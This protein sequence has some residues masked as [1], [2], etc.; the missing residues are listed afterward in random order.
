[1]NQDNTYSTFKVCQLEDIDTL[2]S[3]IKMK[4]NFRLKDYIRIIRKVEKT[5]MPSRLKKKMRQHVLPLVIENN[6]KE[7]AEQQTKTISERLDDLKSTIKEFES[8]QNIN[9][10]KNNNENFWNKEYK[11]SDFTIIKGDISILNYHLKSK[12]ITTIKP[13]WLVGIEHVFRIAPE[14]RKKAKAHTNQFHF[15]PYTDLSYLL[16]EVKRKVDEKSREANEQYENNI[17]TRWR[18]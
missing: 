13:K 4:G 9:D 18:N 3:L 7:I 11:A 14:V 2:I 5:D 10:E 16:N 17:L 1:M 12:R 6:P 15:V 8:E